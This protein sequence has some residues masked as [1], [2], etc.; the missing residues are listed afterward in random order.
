MRAPVPLAAVRSRIGQ[1]A[2][3]GAVSVA[4]TVLDF[5]LFNLFLLAE[6]LPVVVANTIS[7]GSG[8]VASY[9]L[10]KHLTFRGGGR[11]NRT[12][13]IALFVAFNLGGL[14]LNNLAVGVAAGAVG[15]APL[16]LN[17]AKLAAGVVTWLVKFTAFDRWVYPTAPARTDDLG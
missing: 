11:D 13:E 2:T 6:A 4:T 12:H 14:W 15:G 3:F 1:I 16:V 10:N 8:I 17:A 5:G 7:Y 9:L